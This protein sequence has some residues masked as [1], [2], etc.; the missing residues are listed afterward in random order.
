MYKT[1]QF[2]CQQDPRWSHIHL[3]VSR[4]TVGQ[5]GCYECSILSGANLIGANP[6]HETPG[7]IAVIRAD[8]DPSGEAY[9]ALIA[10]QLGLVFDGR[11][12]FQND[13]KILEYLRDPKKFCVLD[14]NH[15]RHFVLAWHQSTPGNYTVADPWTGKLVDAKTVYHNIVGVRYF[16]KA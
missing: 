1:P 5:D 14:V 12:N 16:S 3:G 6:H 13:A 2:F 11:D 4:V 8:F 15:G 10:K 7:T 9:A